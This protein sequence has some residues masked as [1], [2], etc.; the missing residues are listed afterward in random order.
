MK[1]LCACMVILILSLSLTGCSA[2][3]SSELS[4]EIVQEALDIPVYDAFEG[5][6]DFAFE[7]DT[8]AQPDAQFGI[9]TEDG[10]YYVNPVFY[11]SKSG[12]QLYFYDKGADTSIPVCSKSDC[13]HEDADCDAFFDD[14]RYPIMSN[15]ELYAYEGDLYVF[16]VDKGYYSIE[17]VSMD[18]T[19]RET[20]CRLMRSVRVS[21]TE[22]GMQNSAIYYPR[23]CIHRG[24]VYFSTEYPGCESAEL[25]RVKLEKEAEV[26]VLY[27]VAA[28]VPQLYRLKPYGCY[29]FFQSGE[30]VDE[31]YK[32]DLYAF[33]TEEDIIYLVHKN[34]A[35][36]FTVNESALFYVDSS[37]NI[38]KADLADGTEEIFHENTDTDQMASDEIFVKDGKLY[39]TVVIINGSSTQYEVDME[40][41]IREIVSIEESGFTFP[42]DGL[43]EPYTPE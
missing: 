33:D 1:R 18:G 32:I 6:F 36:N 16:C 2:N 41:N 34:V 19:E 3:G 43:V 42:C 4:T 40:K 21:S 15:D 9:Y 30:V 29:L 27:T 13:L 39:H 5:P 25:C 8:D 17:R 35:R 20:V 24:Y 22:D 12:H 7:M 38:R 10:L 31:E 37:R 26:E 23:I 11:G 14:S 28:D